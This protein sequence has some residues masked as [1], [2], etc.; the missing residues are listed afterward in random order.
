M[1]P[2]NTRVKLTEQRYVY[3]DEVRLPVRV[4]PSGFEFCV[5]ESWLKHRYGQ[6]IILTWDEID[7]LRGVL[8]T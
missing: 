8:T 1:K 2:E 6:R 7:R 4:M 3:L 5:K